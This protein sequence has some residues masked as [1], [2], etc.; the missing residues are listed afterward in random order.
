MV[1]AFNASK[2]PHVIKGYCTEQ[3]VF[4]QFVKMWDKDAN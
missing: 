4:N 1:V 3:E 2:H